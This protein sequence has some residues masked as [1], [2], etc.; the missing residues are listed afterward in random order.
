MFRVKVVATVAIAPEIFR[1]DWR[2]NRS[3]PEGVV[4]IGV[5]KDVE[6]KSFH[7]V[8]D[9]VR[10]GDR[11]PAYVIVGEEVYETYRAALRAARRLAARVEAD[12]RWA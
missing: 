10:P 1:G 8:R 4:V 9:F 7:L 6:A 2:W 12:P 11:S 5:R 3:T